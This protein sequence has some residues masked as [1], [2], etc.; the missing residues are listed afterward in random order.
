MVKML[1][2]VVPDTGIVNFLPI[3]SLKVN[4]KVK[5]IGLSNFQLKSTLSFC[6]EKPILFPSGNSTL[7][8]NPITSSS[9]SYDKFKLSYPSFNIL[10]NVLVSIP[11]G[12]TGI[13]TYRLLKYICGYEDV[14]FRDTVQN[15][16][17][18]CCFCDFMYR[19]I[20]L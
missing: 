13:I 14:P 16:I 5:L 1:L 9:N 2:S 4:N 20:A 10:K 19:G 8:S 18:F 17:L 15:F 12:T 6:L 3:S 7:T 11:N